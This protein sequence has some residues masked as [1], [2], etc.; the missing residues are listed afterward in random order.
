MD[1]HR[2]HEIAEKIQEI[3]SQELKLMEGPT[4]LPRRHARPVYLTHFSF[5]LCVL[6]GAQ[7]GLGLMTGWHGEPL[8]LTNGDG[9]LVVLLGFITLR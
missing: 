1:H 7:S 3:D 2:D 9:S 6:G 8:P 5:F 4:S